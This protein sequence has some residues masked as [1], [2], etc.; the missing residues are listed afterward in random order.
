MIASNLLKLL[1]LVWNVT[2]F[3]WLIK[4]IANYSL[5]KKVASDVKSVIN[6]C[7]QNTPPLP[8]IIDTKLLV[9]DVKK[10]IDAD[11]ID[12]PLIDDSKISEFLSELENALVTTIEQGKKL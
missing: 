9:D 6:N 11:I 8:S 1:S 7:T 2:T 4:I 5:L 3:K 12:I 10:L